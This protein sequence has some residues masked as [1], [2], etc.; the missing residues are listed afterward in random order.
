MDTLIITTREDL[1]ATIND[2]IQKAI[3]ESLPETIR[4]ANIKPLL[5]KKELSELTGWSLR[6]I[7]Y[8][9]SRGEIEYKQIGRSILFPTE[10]VFEYL[11]AGTVPRRKRNK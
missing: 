8:L 1:E 4:R 3:L 6:K 11:D 9:K 7:D 2:T 10:K 5:T